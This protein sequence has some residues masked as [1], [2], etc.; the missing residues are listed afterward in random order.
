[1]DFTIDGTAYKAGKMDA[2]KQLSVLSKLSPLLTSGLPELL[3]LLREVRVQGVKIIDLPLEESV[4]KLSPL[5]R[6]IAKMS[7][8]DRRTIIEPCLAVVEKDIGGGK[9]V[10]VWNVQA[11]M[12]TQPEIREDAFLMLRI[13][14]SVITGTFSRFFPASR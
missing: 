11:Q 3:P 2:F 9:F 7:E 6:E 13:V 12:S 8:D 5:A 4:A 14:F 10:P 1:M